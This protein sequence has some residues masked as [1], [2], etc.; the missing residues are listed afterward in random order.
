MTLKACAATILV[1]DLERDN[2]DIQG[3]IENNVVP[4]LLEWA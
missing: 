3:I 4:E 2:P 1:H